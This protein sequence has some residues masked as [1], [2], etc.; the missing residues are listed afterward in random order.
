[1]RQPK[2][3]QDPLRTPLNEFMGTEG[4]VRVLRVLSLTRDPMARN[5]VAVRAELHPT[6]VRRILD[7]LAESGLL[8]TVGTGRGQ[9]VLLR[10]EHPMAM[11]IRQ[12]F[13]EE[14]EA[15]ERITAAVRNALAAMSK[16][17][18]AVWLENPKKRTPGI[19]DLGVLAAPPAVDAVTDELEERLSPLG[20]SLLVHFVTHGYTDLDPDML[21]QE[22]RERLKDVTLLYGWIPLRWRREGGGPIRSHTELDERAR[23]LASAIANRLPS[24]P[25]IVERAIEWI[26]ERLS[27]ASAREA[28][29]LQQWHKILTRLSTSQ[30]QKI[31]LE[32]SERARELRQSLP[33]AEVLSPQERRQIMTHRGEAIDT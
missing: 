15:F 14:R 29:A 1:M 17:V 24:D 32:D 20:E 16:P 33:F 8:A 27:V 7:S 2:I 19:A 11:S 23:R 18:E 30:I 26:E 3:P 13:R 5:A 10:D 28:P 9:A 12:L 25:T 4:S 21:H 31:L 22:Q 6:G